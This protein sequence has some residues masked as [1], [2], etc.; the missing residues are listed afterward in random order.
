M[1]TLNIPKEHL[2]KLLCTAS[3]DG[4]LLYLYLQAGGNPDKAESALR[5]SDTR[6]ACATATLRQLGLWED[7]KKAPIF[8]GERPQ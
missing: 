1:D 8:S 5:M 2:Q 4:A 7:S 3:G 6:L